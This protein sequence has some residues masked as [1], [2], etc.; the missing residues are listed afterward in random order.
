MDDFWMSVNKLV[1][2]AA[3][4][5]TDPRGRVLLVKPNYRDHWN[6][7]GGLIDA[8]E[9]PSQACA[10]E[11]AEE[12]GLTTTPGSLLVTQ[13]LM[14]LDTCPLPSVHFMFDCGTLDPDTP[15]TLQAEEL[16]DYGFFPMETAAELLRPHAFARLSAAASARDSGA[17][18]FLAPENA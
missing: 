12:L 9:H 8:G 4:Y 16:D 5:I 10:R 6:F 2:A 13:W 7:A 14:P 11:V 1:A 15:I 3:A 17:P 18:S